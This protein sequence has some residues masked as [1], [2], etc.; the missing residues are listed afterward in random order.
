[1]ENESMSSFFPFAT[2][3]VT[4][5]VLLSYLNN[6][7]EDDNRSSFSL[8]AKLPHKIATPAFSRQS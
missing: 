5:V 3:N 2:N 8:F 7:V 4:A 1:M 6:C